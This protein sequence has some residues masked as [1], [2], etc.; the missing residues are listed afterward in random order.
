MIG[1]VFEQHRGIAAVIILITRFFRPHPRWR[2]AG[3]A[4]GGERQGA[5]Q[6]QEE[7]AQRRFPRFR[8]TNGQ[9]SA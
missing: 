9:N 2:L 7:M 1:V 8:H 6:N 5:E 3:P 4:T